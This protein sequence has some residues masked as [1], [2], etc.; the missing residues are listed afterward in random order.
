MK[1]PDYGNIDWEDE[2]P[3]DPNEPNL[4]ITI[5]TDK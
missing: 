5:P 1:K 4:K 3:D 2:D